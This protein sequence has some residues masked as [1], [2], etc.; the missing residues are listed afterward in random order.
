[1]TILN[2]MPI[3][4]AELAAKSGSSE[5]VVGLLASVVLLTAAIGCVI[6]TVAGHVLP[7]VAGAV[8]CIGIAAAAIEQTISTAIL[9]VGAAIVGSS[10]GMVLAVPLSRSSGVDS[11]LRM[12]SNGMAIGCVA[13]FAL[14]AGIHATGISLL[15]PLALLAAIQAILLLLHLPPPGKRNVRHFNWKQD[16]SLMPFFI[17]MGAYWAF[18]EVFSIEQDLGSLSAW[19]AAS[20]W[21]SALGSFIAGI[22]LDRLRLHAQIVGLLL[23]AFAGGLTYLS[24]SELLMGATIL[25]NAF[26]LF[27]FFPLYLD[28]TDAPASGMARYLLGFAMGGGMG[29]LAIA[30]GGYPALASAVVISGLIALPA[31][32]RVRPKSDIPGF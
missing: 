15:L 18:L 14:L 29:S 7:R 19:L 26:G 17:C 20:L 24:S 22:I 4:L 9:F 23:A 5:V 21:L 11:V 30:M 8:A 10:L 32:M 12:I 31:L 28:R 16:L 6:G 2:T 27:L 13:S 1:M 3:W 25:V